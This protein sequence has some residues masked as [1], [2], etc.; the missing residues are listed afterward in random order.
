MRPAEASDAKD[1]LAKFIA[2]R[3][4]EQERAVNISKS[5]LLVVMGTRVS[6]PGECDCCSSAEL[7]LTLFRGSAVPDRADFN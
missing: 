1:D 2:L 4:R 7:R 6:N 5:E 3:M